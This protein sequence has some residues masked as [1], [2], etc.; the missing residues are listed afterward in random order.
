MRAM[1][2]QITSES[3]VCSTVFEPNIHEKIKA[4]VAN[5]LWDES[6]IDRWIRLAKGQ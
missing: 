1:V 6:T 5:P 4:S 3:S 2:T